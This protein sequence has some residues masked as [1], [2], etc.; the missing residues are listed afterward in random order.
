MLAGG[1]GSRLGALTSKVPKP[2]LS[3]G[4]RPFLE[5]LLDRLIA[6]GADQLILSLHH[7]PEAVSG[8]FGSRY[9]GVPIRYAVEPAPL[10]TGGAIAYALRE[11]R[12]APLLVVNGDSF[13]AI[14]YA[15]LMH[16]YL[17][18]P[19]PVAL[20]VR[21]VPDAGRYGAVT[22]NGE[23]ALAFAEKGGHGPALISTGTYIL[24]PEVFARF[25]LA[26]RFSIE[27]DLLQRHCAALRPRAYS[28]DGYFIDI[29]VAGD[30]DRAQLELPV[31][32]G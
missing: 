17:R 13:L 16:W 4:G 8:H 7:L 23:T 12:A 10:G 32:H 14:D 9:R 21:P 25:G 19:V 1:L 27:T 29:G 28:F 24:R 26:G 11:E 30:L 22:V 20:V 6:G 18:D 31:F 2:M 3:V 15:A 5:Y